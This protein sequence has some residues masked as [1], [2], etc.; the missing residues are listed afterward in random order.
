M[1]YGRGNTASTF[2]LINKFVFADDNT[3]ALSGVEASD[4]SVDLPVK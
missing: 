4:K 2:K 1:Y 3:P